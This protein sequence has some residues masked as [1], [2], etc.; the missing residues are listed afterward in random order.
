MGVVFI[1][2]IPVGFQIPGVFF[3]F[4]VFIEFAFR[5][6]AFFSQFFDF[7]VADRAVGEFHQPGIDGDAFVD[8]EPLLFELF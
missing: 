5:G 8:G 6:L 1:F 7:V 3:G 4:T 2:G